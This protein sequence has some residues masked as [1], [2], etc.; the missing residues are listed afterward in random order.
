MLL[1]L[2]EE[3]YYDNYFELFMTD[4]WKQFLQEIEDILS[5]HRIEDIKDE[6]Q[7]AFVKGE[8]DA[9]FRVRR[10]ATGI[11]SNYSIIKER[12]SDA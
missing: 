12:E 11:Q 8:R 2:E 3:K 7:L 6:K 4:G 10:F 5:A 9:L 1:T